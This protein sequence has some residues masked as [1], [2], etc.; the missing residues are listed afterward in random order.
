MEL[1]MNLLRLEDIEEEITP[2][3][4]LKVSDFRQRYKEG[5]LT[6][7]EKNF[8]IRRYYDLRKGGWIKDYSWIEYYGDVISVIVEKLSSLE[9]IRAIEKAEAN[10]KAHLKTGKFKPVKIEDITEWKIDENGN[11][12]SADGSVSMDNNGW[13]TFH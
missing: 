6:N 7:Q 11:R 12:T 2:Q 9:L 8:L 4:Q 3:E 10:Q 1:K 13:I 5:D